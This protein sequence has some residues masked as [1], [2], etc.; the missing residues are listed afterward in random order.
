LI[1]VTFAVHAV[2]HVCPAWPVFIA[3]RSPCCLAELHLWAEDNP[4]LVAQYL[5]VVDALNFCF[6]PQPGLEYEQLATGVKLS[7]LRTPAALSAAS[8]AGITEP[9]VNAFL[10]GTGVPA[11]PNAPERARLLR[12]VGIALLERWDGQAANMVR[13]AKGSAPAL[14]SLLTAACPGFQDHSIYRS[15]QVFF[16]KRAQ[17][18]VG[19]LHGAFQGRGLGAFSDIDQ[20]TMFADYRVPVVLREMGILTYAPALAERVDGKVEL[21][22]GGMEEVE[23]RA[24]SVVAV[25]RL[26]R[27]VHSRALALAGSIQ[28]A[29][30]LTPPHALQ[31]DWFLWTEGERQRER[32]PPHH[33]TRTIFY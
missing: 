3:P 1:K 26:R 27:A 20:L 16:Y 4:E 7:A 21:S 15:A 30:R 9:E 33:R 29:T 19:D 13:A 6:W 8:L 12:E 5:L 18:F 14:V 31:V 32:H 17:I 24:A 22:A 2:C 11:F 10:T 25:E 23:I 28:D